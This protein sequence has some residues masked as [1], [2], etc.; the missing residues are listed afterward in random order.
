MRGFRAACAVML[1]AMSAVA[2]AGEAVVVKNVIGTELNG[3]VAGP[4]NSPVGLLV[5]HDRWGLNDAVRATVDRYGNNGYRVLA[6]DMYDGRSTE[7]ERWRADELLRE[8]DREMVKSNVLAGL[9]Y[10]QAPNRK[11]ATLGSGFGGW[12]SFQAAVMAP[13]QVVATVVI[14]S[15]LD[16]DVEQ[17]RSLEGAVMAVFASRDERVTA[18]MREEYRIKMRKGFITYRPHVYEVDSGFMDLRSPTYHFATAETVWQEVDRFLL[19]T[20]GK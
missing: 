13:K 16:A 11:L 12:Q 20:L 9:R 1:W 17:V 10:L 8:T 5:L 18:E 4:E 15:S 19:A 14:D 2:A 7:N 3:Y 6:L